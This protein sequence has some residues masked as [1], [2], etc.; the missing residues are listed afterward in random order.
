[1]DSTS[2]YAG[3]TVTTSRKEKTTRSKTDEKL[4]S[5]ENQNP[6]V[7][8]PGL[9]LCRSP[10]IVKSGKGAKKS[11]PRKANP[12]QIASPSTKKK[13]RE[14]R[15]VV[16]K[17]KLNSPGDDVACEK[18]KKSIGKSKCLCVAYENLRVSQDDFFKDRCEIVNDFD[19]TGSENTGIDNEG[20]NEENSELGLKRS[21]DRLLEAARQ[22]VPET[23]SGRV[24]HLVMAFE[25]LRMI[26]KSGVS[27]ENEAEDD[28]KVV[29]WALPG[30]QQPRAKVSE[31]QVSSSSFSP[32]ELCL[33]SENLGLDSGRS[34][35]L[36]SS[37]GSI[38]TRTSNGGRKSRRSSIE[39]SG[40]VNKRHSK[41]KQKKETSQKPFML[42][43]EQRGRSKE[44]QLTKKL[45][46]MLEEEDKSRIRVALG[47]PWTTDE[48]EFLVKPPVKENTRPVDLVLHSDTRAVERTE[49]DNQVV[50]KM[51]M[52]EQYQMEKERQQKQ[53]E[54]EE[55]KRLRKELVIKAQPMPYFDRPFIPRRSMKQLT[56]PKDPKFH[57]P[58]SKKI[59]CP[60]SLDD[61]LYT[62]LE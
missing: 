54:E 62:Q 28:K 16:A 43:T 2:K 7:S 23:G 20:E 19:L 15:F 49:F 38:S 35:S 59:K 13:I 26:Q 44:E 41:R 50:K 46:Q 51:N 39:S 60:L 24:M 14:R 4:K 8:I 5:T 12:S 56:I 37:Q 40:T 27:E 21:R 61:D 34:Y 33:T 58:Q 18:C 17:R 31:S 32:S 9:K 47:L 22:S 42:R 36:D 25:K 48:P 55:I 3:A 6:N 11:V 53:A 57:L 1:M 30:L 10:T 52:I 29:K 45:Q